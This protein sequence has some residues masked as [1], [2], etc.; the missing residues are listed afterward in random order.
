[1]IT[2]PKRMSAV[3]T[4]LLVAVFSLASLS[5]AS[6]V[7]DK[8]GVDMK[9]T[10][11]DQ[12]NDRAQAMSASSDQERM[13]FIRSELA[14]ERQKFQPAQENELAEPVNSATAQ[15]LK[16]DSD[17]A[18]YVGNL[19]NQYGA[20]T[21]GADVEADGFEPD[22][23]HNQGEKLLDGSYSS[24]HTIYP[25]DD[26]DFF[27]FYGDAGAVVEIVTQTPN[28]Y[29]GSK[30]IIL[31]PS[32]SDLDP[33]LTLYLPDRTVYVDNDDAGPGWDAF[34]NIQLPQSG[35]YYISVESSDVWG[36]T[37]TVGSY[38]I[39]LSFIVP[40]EFEADDDMASATTIADRQTLEGHTIMPSV[41][42]DFFKFEVANDYTFLKAAVV[43]TPSAQNWILDNW[44][45]LYLHDLDP[46][47]ELYDANGVLISANDDDDHLLPMDTELGTLDAEIVYPRNPLEDSPLMAGTYYLKV[48]ASPKSA[49]LT[50]VGS[51]KLTLELVEPDA[52][53][54]F[55]NLL[56]GAT[57]IADGETATGHT[58][59]MW[60]WD[61][62]S[63]EG[64][65]GSF[66]EISVNTPNPCGRLDPVVYLWSKEGDPAM[67]HP[68]WDEG[69]G[70]DAYIL[71]GPLPYSGT[72]YIEV[73]ADLMTEYWQTENYDDYSLTVSTFSYDGHPPAKKKWAQPIAVGET[74]KNN[75]IP[76]TGQWWPWEDPDILS[77]MFGTMPNWFVFEGQEG[78]Q[79]DIKVTTPIQKRGICPL[80][81]LDWMDD[82]NPEVTLM[83][84]KMKPDGTLKTG[85][86]PY[87][88]NGNIDLTEW[89]DDCEINFVLPYTGTFYIVVESQGLIQS[90]IPSWPDDWDLPTYS[91]GSFDLKLVSTP[92]VV[93]FDS[94][95]NLGQ[96]PLFINYFDHCQIADDPWAETFTWDASYSMGY[97]MNG[98]NPYYCY[99]Q[100]RLIGTH[101]VMKEAANGAGSVMTVKED[102]VE[103]YGP[104]GY[105]PLVVVDGMG[106]YPN[107]PWAAAVDA[108]DYCWNGV[109]TVHE[110]TPGAYPWATFSFADGKTK[111]V[112]KIR[113]KTDAGMGNTGRW[114]RKVRVSANDMT[115]TDDY[116]TVAE[117]MIEGGGW[118][119][120]EI[121]PA[122]SAANLKLEVMDSDLDFVGWRQI[123]EFEAYEDIVVPS[124]EKSLLTATTPHLANGEDAAQ[125]TVKLVD[126][127]G[128]PITTYDE[129]DIQFYMT[130]CEAGMF[131]PLDLSEAANGIYKTTLTMT[132]AGGYQVFAAAHGAVIMTDE[133]GDNQEATIVSFFG[134]SGQ[135]G[136]LVFVEGSETSKGEGWDN[137]IDGDREGWDGTVTTKGDPV[138]AIFKFSNGMKMPINKIGLATDNGFDDDAY[139]NRQAYLFEV[140]VSDDM[141]D[142]TMILDEVRDNVGEMDYFRPDQIYFGK[143][144]KLVVKQPVSGWVQLVEFEVLFDSKEG[145][146]AEETE[147]AAVPETFELKNNYPNPFNPTTT[148]NYQLPEQR[149]V[150]ISV[151]NVIGQHI[152][153]LVDAN[154][155]AGYHSVVWDAIDQSSGIYL[156]RIEAGDFVQTQR[157]ILLK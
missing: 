55:D 125:I 34:I 98:K 4:V 49:F 102:F 41:D 50:N 113:I 70:L 148:I 138:Y 119:E 66:I 141:V 13:S 62:F 26:V 42:V 44:Y 99:W 89:W 154:M 131:G 20:T 133:P 32:E 87:A 19:N 124:M 114:A 96:A 10:I 74:L 35:I 36:P 121:S 31:P 24:K 95:R 83:G 25:G 147:V 3:L 53:E 73:G 59:T 37:N 123:A 117:M 27:W 151:Y 22:N 82:L 145:F 79:V 105:A 128:N 11:I 40:D 7:S 28:P 18:E 118:N 8:V 1:M 77:E 64:K 12:V 136:E 56:P 52:W 101:D 86:M 48:S 58:I 61:L 72:Y 51:Y 67:L 94:D 153:T 84:Y 39:G 75:K 108:D 92:R 6:T 38:G 81:E 93:D 149:H 90:I 156:Y 129:A 112:N 46:M 21:L 65:R 80:W 97:E 47:I 110:E 45:E 30:G 116:S 126:V 130:N 152:A 57:P 15:E 111:M 16:I 91:Y 14:K 78:Q 29:W 139:E 144:I 88:Y 60:D 115:P 43:N 155:N 85:L 134:A 23:S 54:P 106:D 127:D 104:G 68:S 142:W 150:R 120:L 140:Y 103:L 63:F 2:I 71:W 76:R 17:K 157:M 137:A 5:L 69:E 143:Y 100:P 122:I 107:E 9:Q 132:E 146:Q 109:A 135:K 33:H